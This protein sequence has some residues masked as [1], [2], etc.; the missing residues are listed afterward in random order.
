[1]IDGQTYAYAIEADYTSIGDDLVPTSREVGLGTYASGSATLTRSVLNSTNGNAL[2]NLAGD[3][4]VIITLQAGMFR[5]KLSAARTYYVR[6]DGNDSN[7]GLVNSAAGAFLT[8]QHAYDI[9]C[10]IDTNGFDVTI[11]IGA[12]TFSSAYGINAAASWGGGGRLLID[13]AGMA[14]TT[15]NATNDA[16]L[17]QTTLSAFLLI[18]D[19]KI[20]TTN[21]IGLYHIG[22]GVMRFGRIDFGATGSYQIYAATPTAFIWANDGY[23]IS[24]GTS[25]HLLAQYGS[26]Q[27]N[28][29]TMTFTGTPAF[30]NAFALATRGGKIGI[31]ANTFSPSTGAFT[32][33]R[34]SIDSGGLIYTGT[35]NVNYL[36]GSAAGSGGTTTGGGFYI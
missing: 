36:P 27:A 24:G 28:G 31:D 14:S 7:T 18:N 23:T 1:M 13:G 9:I 2:L 4:Q 25:F 32:G 20:T 12:G 10:G 21:G 30:A 35:G 3:E 29:L 34:Y 15:V 5:D 22:S 6:T 33:S 19:L 26:I 16:F 11:S 8:I 17:F